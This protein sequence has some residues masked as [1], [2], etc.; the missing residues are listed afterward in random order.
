[1]RSV[2]D[3]RSALARIDVR[4]TLLLAGAAAAFTSLLL[5][6]LLAYAIREDFEEQLR[7]LDD[8]LDAVEAAAAAGAPAPATPLRHSGAYRVVDDR[9]RV[10]AESGVWPPEDTVW[11]GASLRA[12]LGATADEH[13]AGERRTAKGGTVAAALPLRHFVRERRELATRA[14]GVVILGILGAIGL[15]IA[16]ARRALR[17]LRDTTAAIRA[18]DPRRLDTRI[19]L[20]GTDDDVDRL[21]STTNDVL[22]RLEWAF[23]RMSAFSADVAHELRTPV[24]R[25]LNTA[26]VALTTTA[27]PAAKDDALE[28]VHDT[29]EAMR[30]TIEQLLLLAR[31]EDGRLLLVRE[32]IDLGAVLEGLVE[33]YAPA[34]ERLGK[35]ITLTPA[36]VEVRADRRLVER[37]VANLVE[38]ALRHSASGAR[39]RLGAEAANGAAVI[40]VED[41]GPGVGAAD[42]TRIFERFVRADDARGPGGV[43]LGL[44]IAR[45]IARLHQ[46]ELEV[47]DSVLGG[48]A[49]RLALARAIGAAETAGAAGDGARGTPRPAAGSGHIRSTAR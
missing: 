3:L 47:G 43:G 39:I 36:S 38:N 40:V 12:A 44:P 19:P 2:S 18:I 29:A 14:T 34:A 35:T 17:P 1:M 21:A 20:R 42:R 5:C 10:V 16:G 46:G 37:A 7:F 22:A 48:A 28:A 8:A 11:H 33:L 13:I 9:G 6:G 30:R 25:V 24:N 23:E 26:E 32:P 45:M 15:G 49:F 27:D 31:G 41:S 4:L